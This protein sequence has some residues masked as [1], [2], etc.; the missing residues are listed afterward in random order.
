MIEWP[1]MIVKHGVYG[2]DADKNARHK[3][4]PLLKIVNT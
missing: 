3:Y 4:L 1:L 2:F